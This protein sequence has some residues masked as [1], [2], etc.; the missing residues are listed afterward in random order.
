MVLSRRTGRMRET[1]P[2]L[3]GTLV[4]QTA[5]NILALA[6]LGGD[7]RRLH[8]PL[9]ARAR[10]QLFVFSLAPLLSWSAVV[11]A[12]SSCVRR[13][14]GPDRRAI[15]RG[16]RR[17]S[18]VRTGPRRLPRP[19][20]RAPFA[21]GAQLARLGQSSCWPARRCSQAL[22]LHGKLGI[23]AAAAVLFAV[24]VTAVVPATPSNIGVFQ[25]AVISVLTTGFGV[26]AADAL[27][28]G[29]I[30]QAVEIATA[31]ALGLPALV[32][33]GADLVRHA[34]A[35]PERGAGSPLA[36]AR[37]RDRVREVGQPTRG[38]G[39]FTASVVASAGD[40]AF[41]H[42]RLSPHRPQRELKFATEGYWRGE[43]SEPELLETAKRIRLD[44]WRFMQERGDRPDPLQRLLPLR[45]GARHDRPG[46]RRAGPLRA[47]TAG[48]VGLDT[49]FAMARGRQED[50]VD[51][52]AMEMTKWFDTNYHYI[53]PE[54]GP[55]TELLAVVHEALRRARR[56]DGG[57]GDRHGAGDRRAGLVPA[58]RQVRRRRPRGLRPP[59]PARA[60]ARGL[61]RGDRAAR[62]AG[63]DL[64][65]ARRALLR[66]G[67][68][69]ARARRAAARL[70]GARQGPRAHPDLRQD[71]LRP[72]RRRLRRAA[73]SA[74]RGHRPRLP[75]RGCG[76][77]PARWSA[78][79]AE[80]RRADRRRGRP[81][82]QV[83]VRRDRRRAQRLDQRAR[84]QPRPARRPARPL[85]RAGGLHLAA[86]SCT[87]PS[88]STPSRRRTRSTTSC[89]PG[90]RSPSRRSARSR[91][92]PRASA[93]AARR[94]RPSSTPTTGR[95]RTGANSHRTR[96]PAVRDAGRGA[97]RRGRAPRRAR[98][99]S[100]ARPST[101]RLDLPLFPT[102][103]I[104]S[105][106]QTAE[107]RQA[108]RRASRG[109]D[110]PRRVRASGCA[111][112]SSG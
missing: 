1:F 40:G 79:A 17:R 93:R 71:L 13:T 37:R 67:P 103:T 68:L 60:A 4:S 24:N 8:G 78:R 58:A 73:R 97:D 53:V 47:R 52:T 50:G 18:A 16:P 36:A 43:V 55:D 45:P 106:P 92:S 70:R 104:G 25:L 102:T 83:A 28:Y 111:P 29:V 32:R 84:A 42:R 59:R 99:R 27:A 49:Y 112:R 56:G 96:N 64:G 91:R 86:R 74:D 87:R 65:A 44:N 54:L 82:G 39:P 75:S 107:I 15:R 98:S 100:A 66:R 11:L 62:R 61:R 85:R 6:L 77:R 30:L 26:G 101:A 22:G 109:R 69:R 14:A 48:Q 35:R 21:A 76:P 7:H 12:P 34:P 95:S 108:P 9:P 41:E 90:W 81:R 19:A 23:G 33:E 72:R 20:P 105:Y 88:T 57:A 38:L 80:E 3:L 51:V 10:Q 2:V 110:R 89:A 63:R 5:L 94:S 46:R 31:V